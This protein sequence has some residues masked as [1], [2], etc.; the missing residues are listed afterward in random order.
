MFGN[1]IARR[2]LGG[3][4]AFGDVFGKKKKSGAE[5]SRTEKKLSFFILRPLSFT[6]GVGTFKVQTPK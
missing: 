6:W 4:T 5:L 1:R 3:R 2:T